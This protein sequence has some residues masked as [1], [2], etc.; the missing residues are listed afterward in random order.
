M[1]RSWR[2]IPK[3]ETRAQ[4]ADLYVTL[5]SKGTIVMNKAA[6]EKLKSPEA[7][8]LLYEDV[9]RTI[10]LRPT[11]ASRP[12]AH[13]VQRSGRHGG[14]KITAFQLLTECGLI[15]KETL[16]FHDAE[17]DPS[18]ILILDLRTARASNRALNHPTR[19]E[20]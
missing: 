17:I 19:K 6:Y 3:G 1:A 20:K 18:G 10:G 4:W 12:D 11:N 14:K 5:N 16:E 7:F 2:I 9:N 8:L 15:V 13:R